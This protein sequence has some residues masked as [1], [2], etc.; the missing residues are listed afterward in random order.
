[1]GCGKSAESIRPPRSNNSRLDLGHG[2]GVSEDGHGGH[3]LSRRGL[4]EM[5]PAPPLHEVGAADAD[6]EDAK[7]DESELC[8]PC[9]DEEQAEM[10]LCLPSVYQPT[11]SE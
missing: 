4:G 1:M 6:D 10:P 3:E 2:R 9:E 11:R 5:Q 8:A 7:L